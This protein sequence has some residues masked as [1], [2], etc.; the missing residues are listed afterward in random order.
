M[1]DD[2]D[3]FYVGGG[4]GPINKWVALIGIII[5]VVVIVASS[6]KKEECYKKSCTVGDPVLIRGDCLC[7]E[8]AQ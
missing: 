5:L 1:F 4:T 7:I 3:D 6:S 8:S 2:D